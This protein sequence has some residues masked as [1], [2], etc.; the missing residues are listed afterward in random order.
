MTAPPGAGNL[1]EKAA[2]ITM[3]AGTPILIAAAYGLSLLLQT[4]F[5]G[6]FAWSV[7]GAL[8]GVAATAPMCLFLIWFMRSK[9]AFIAQFRERQIEEFS[10]IGFLFTPMRIVLIAIGAG[11][12]EEILFRGVLQG[13]AAARLPIAAAIILPSILFGLMHARS[14]LYIL[15]AGLIGCWLGVVYWLS[16]NLLAPIIAHALYDVFAL[17]VTRRAI[18]AQPRVE[19]ESG[20]SVTG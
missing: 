1:S 15:I 19:A 14:S 7:E 4:P 9:S 2:L 13:Y 11:V 6:D 18:A 17:D 10:K 8:I 12:S 16:G 5:P 3:F 20:S